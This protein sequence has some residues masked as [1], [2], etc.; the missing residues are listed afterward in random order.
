MDLFKKYQDYSKFELTQAFYEAC[1][2]DKLEQAQH[3]LENKQYKINPSSEEDLGFRLT[4][5]YG[6]LSVLKYL[7]NQKDYFPNIHAKNDSAFKLATRMQKLEVIQ[8]LIF[9][10][11][12]SKTESISKFLKN[13]PN[14]SVES[15]FEARELNKQLEFDFNSPKPALKL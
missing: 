7:T 11:N 5:T 2:K 1:S 12:I 9:D 8:F 14:K 6:S 13:N 4:C 10:L 15:M 3:L